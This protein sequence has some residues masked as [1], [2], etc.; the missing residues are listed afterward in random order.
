MERTTHEKTKASAFAFLLTAVG[1]IAACF[2]GC[3][4]QGSSDSPSAGAGESDAPV[5]QGDFTFSD[6]AD[7]AVCHET[8]SSSTTNASCPA[9]NH[10]A[11]TC[12]D[13][14]NDTGGL[15]AAHEGV[16]YG[17]KP[18]KRLKS[19]VVEEATCLA[20]ACHGSYEALAEKTASSTVLTDKNS[21]VVNPHALP[22]NEDHD[23]IDCGSCHS[24]HAS[25]DISETAQKA[26]LGC[27]HM[28]IYECNTCHD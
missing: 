26:C 28:S 7:C 18:A 5:M 15:T 22:E 19:T 14:H 21:V 11:Q 17:D 4:P 12:I 27:H 20:E 9:S 3:A 13:C 23:T 24:M 8:E 2:Y 1:L 16:A 6:D 10:A 25:D